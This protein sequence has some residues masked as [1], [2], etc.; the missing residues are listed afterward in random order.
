M[1]DWM[2]ISRILIKFIFIA[3]IP[4]LAVYFRFK[5]KIKTGFTAGIILTSLILSV[6]GSTSVQEDQNMKFINLLNNHKI[7]E[8]AKA[9]RIVIQYGPERV[10]MIDEKKIVDIELYQKMKNDLAVEYIRIARKQLE[11]FTVTDFTS[12]TDLV[13]QKK[14][15]SSLKHGMNLLKYAE[16]IG[17][18]SP[19]I[20]AGLEKKISKGDPILSRMDEKC[21]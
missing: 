9:F 6:I 7:D 20:K 8:A 5:K 11:N 3:A 15:L 21:D 1:S 17:G 16:S 12:C 4:A 2:Q 14:N 10:A 18:F 19:E 13:T